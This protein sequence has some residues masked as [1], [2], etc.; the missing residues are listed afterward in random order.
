VRVAGYTYVE[1]V[2]G[3]RELH[4]LA[5]DPDQLDNIV[6]S[7]SPAVVGPLQQRLNE[8]RHCVGDARRTAETALLSLTG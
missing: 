2:T 3:E 6:T 8:L 7:A 5:S 1:Y 4:N